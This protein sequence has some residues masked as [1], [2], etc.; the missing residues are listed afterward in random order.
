MLVLKTYFAIP[1][2]LGEHEHNSFTIN[3]WNPDIISPSTGWNYY[4]LHAR[5]E[6]G[7]ETLCLEKGW[8]RRYHFFGIVI[9]FILFLMLIPNQRRMPGRTSLS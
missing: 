6:I 2:I 5:K 3:F 9:S 4:Y 8:E 1:E 7:C